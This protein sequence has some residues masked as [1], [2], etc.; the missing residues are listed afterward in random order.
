[1]WLVAS[2]AAAQ[3]DIF[4]RDD[5]GE[6][7]QRTE[8]SPDVQAY[9]SIGG[10]V[11]F[12]PSV[13]HV[14]RDLIY[15]FA[16]GADNA[17]WFKFLKGDHW[18]PTQVEWAPLYGKFEG[19]PVAVLASGAIEVLAVGLNGHLYRREFSLDT[20]RWYPSDKDSWGNPDLFPWSDLGGDFQGVPAISSKGGRI[21]IVVRGKDDQLWHKIFVDGQ[22]FP[23]YNEW[24][25]IGGKTNHSPAITARGYHSVDIVM[26]GVDG[27]KYRKSLIFPT[28]W[29]PSLAGWDLLARDLVEGP[30]EL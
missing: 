5:K 4:I 19:P 8:A 26:V 16:L 7:L 10:N 18:W 9:I 11:L 6:V 21:D 17:V 28:G 13:V 29:S 12:T 23:S 25:A 20:N 30:V 15:L 27:A 3:V 2:T 1:M 22:W 24:T 14:T